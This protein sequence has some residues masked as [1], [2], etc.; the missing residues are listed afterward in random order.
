MLFVGNNFHSAS[1]R[2]HEKS[3]LWQQQNSSLNTK[4]LIDYSSKIISWK[5]QSSNQHLEYKDNDRAPQREKYFRGQTI[6]AFL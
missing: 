1:R 5:K 6:G 2:L 3:K 4:K